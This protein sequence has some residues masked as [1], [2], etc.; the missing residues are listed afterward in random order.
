MN[1][2]TDTD[3]IKEKIFTSKYNLLYYLIT[4]NLLDTTIFSTL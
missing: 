1:E 2:T 4:G 3:Y